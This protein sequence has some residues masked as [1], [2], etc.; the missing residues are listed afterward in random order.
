M[1]TPDIRAKVFC[2]L[3]EVISG[4]WSDDHCQ[5]TG[6]VRCRGEVVL[7]GSKR[8]E[9]GTVVQLAYRT[10]FGVSQFPRQFRVISSFA[11]PYRRTTTLQVG[12]S[13]TYYE[14]L[15]A[16]TDAERY[17]YSKEDEEN[18]DV[19]CRVYDI[20]QLPISANNIAQRCLRA[21]GLTGST[22]LTNWY[23]LERFD[24]GEGYVAVLSEL[25]YAE[26]KVGYMRD[27]NTLVVVDI[28]STP[29]TAAVANNNNIIDVGPISGGEPAPEALAVRYTYTRYKEPDITKN[30]SP[31]TRWEKEETFG[32]P[33]TVEIAYANET[34]FYRAVTSDYSITETTWDRFNRKLVSR[35]RTR[36]HLADVNGSYIQKLLEAKQLYPSI[37]PIIAPVDTIEEEYNDY[38]RLAEDL[39]EAPDETALECLRASQ[40]EDFYDPDRDNQPVRVRRYTYVSDT[41]IAG[42]LPIEQYHFVNPTNQAI[43]VFHPGTTANRL[44]EYQETTFEKYRENSFYADKLRDPDLDLTK[45]STKTLSA[46]YLVQS[47]QQLSAAEIQ[48]LAFEGGAQIQNII[49]RMALLYSRGISVQII[50]SPDFGSQVRPDPARLADQENRKGISRTESSTELEFILGND[51]SRNVRIYDMPLAPDDRIRFSGSSYPGSWS[52]VKS[53]HQQKAVAFGRA[54]QRLAFGHRNGIS[55]QLPVYA[56]PPYP[57]DPLAVDG[58]TAIGACRVDGMSWAYDANG[59]VC[60]A[61]CL[62]WG[63]LGLSPGLVAP[64]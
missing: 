49:N 31:E 3:G 53:D 57:L 50:S 21:L 15:K 42:R 47:G 52:V 25:L 5:G 2:N 6:L 24:L 28:N 26:A 48:S 17:F 56:M 37:N 55:V 60:N 40:R 33:K 10:T 8:I 54:Q 11:D 51:R 44:A 45:T 19:P 7:Q 12:C 36:R 41:E 58:S 32:E 35:T 20:A 29:A 61:D 22:G 34:K 27:L 64:A 1:T 62:A 59:I 18:K 39:E 30:P 16:A 38:E 4:G 46:L 23:A 9:P 43:T 63:G 13:L 14:N